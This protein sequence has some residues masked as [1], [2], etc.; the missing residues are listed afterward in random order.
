MNDPQTIK[1]RIILKNLN[2][3]NFLREK[4]VVNSQ[5]Y[6]SVRY[7][8]QIKNYPKLTKEEVWQVSKEGNLAATMSNLKYVLE[9]YRNK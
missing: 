1:D 8:N 4:G 7:P 3:A 9:Y 6:F 2:L 5:L